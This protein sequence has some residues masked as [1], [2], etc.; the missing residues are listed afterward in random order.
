MDIGLF[1]A[2]P[3]AGAEYGLRRGLLSAAP[4]DGAAYARAIYGN[5]MRTIALIIAYDGTP[6]AGWQKQSGQRTIQGCLEEAISR[7]NN[8]PTELRAASRTDAGVHAEWQIAAFET[9]RDYDV[10]R[11]KIALNALTPP[12]ITIRHAC[13]APDGFQPRFES[14]GKHYRYW[15]YQ[16]KY[17]PPALLNHASHVRPMDVENMRKAAQYLIGEHDFS[18]FRAAD[19]QA[20]TPIRTITRIEIN[21]VSWPYVYDCFDKGALLQIDVW[22]TAFLKQMVRI[23]VGTLMSFGLG[24][25]PSEMKQI[26]E[27]RDRAQAGETAPACG[28]TLV[29]SFSTLDNILK[30]DTEP[31]KTRD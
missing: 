26:L 24:R 18:A 11:Y 28:L 1:R 2:V 8:A 9:I 13:V 4:R 21:P 16:G 29:R 14:E 12:E 15:L 10:E 23:I 19:C 7:M 5:D 3:R 6:F 17:L 25:N 30:I 27:S 31:P 22:G 20:K